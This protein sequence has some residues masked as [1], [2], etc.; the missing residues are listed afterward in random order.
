MELIP[1]PCQMDEV[2]RKLTLNV[3]SFEA[4]D[5]LV[6]SLSLQMDTNVISNIHIYNIYTCQS[7]IQL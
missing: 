3:P 6:L 4:S 7:L 1:F 2:H 5:T